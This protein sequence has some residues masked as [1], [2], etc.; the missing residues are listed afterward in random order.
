MTTI[1]ISLLIKF[2]IG[3]ALVI[4]GIIIFRYGF[5]LYKSNLE[6]NE[7]VFRFESKLFKIYAKSFG[8]VIFSSAVI[9]M[10]LGALVATRREKEQVLG[11]KKVND[12]DEIMELAW[13]EP[14]TFSN[15]PY[16][17]SEFAFNNR[18]HFL[19]FAD[20]TQKNGFE[21][22]E[23]HLIG[24]YDSVIYDAYFDIVNYLSNQ[25]KTSL[26]SIVSKYN[27]QQ[28]ALL[29]SND[30]IGIYNLRKSKLYEKAV[31]DSI[32]VN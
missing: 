16:P 24:K 28:V 4:A 6:T 9:V 29:V 17:T 22:I 15:L 13:V 2:I 31:R 1:Q 23:G 3:A 30:V 27:K 21:P 25:H 20:S 26:D 12:F 14:Q 19:F 11:L 10:I 32:S 7:D 8:P 5:N 18:D